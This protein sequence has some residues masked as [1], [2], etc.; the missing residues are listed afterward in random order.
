MLGQVH[1]RKKLAM[2]L[3]APRI[4]KFMSVSI[5][6]ELLFLRSNRFN[7]HIQ[8]KASNRLNC[9]LPKITANLGCHLK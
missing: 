9:N 4:I 8:A 5:T 1:V 3:E 6:I 7:E 2:T